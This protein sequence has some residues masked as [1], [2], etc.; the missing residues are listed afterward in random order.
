MNQYTR[1]YEDFN[2]NSTKNYLNYLKWTSSCGKQNCQNK[3][4]CQTWE[5]RKSVFNLLDLQSKIQQ[6]M[7]ILNN[8]KLFFSVLG[9][10][11][12][13]FTQ[14]GEGCLLSHRLFI[15]SPYGGSGQESLWNLFYKRFLYLFISLWKLFIYPVCEDAT[16]MAKGPPKDPIHA[17]HHHWRVGFQHEL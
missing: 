14:L 2:D 4:V 8:I 9:S 16:L 3:V 17:Y 10:K 1:N 13:V 7:S 5:L 11:T 15:V 12:R 6:I